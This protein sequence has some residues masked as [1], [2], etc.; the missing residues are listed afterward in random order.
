MAAR[1]VRIVPMSTEY[2]RRVA[3]RSQKRGVK[4]SRSGRLAGVLGELL[5]TAGVLVLLFLGW[6]VWLG[7]LIIGSTQAAQAQ[8]QSK[9]WSKDEP[10]KPAVPAQRAD[11]G[12]PPA[13]AAPDRTTQFAN[14][15][16]PR[17]GAGYTRPVAEGISGDVLRTN[18][19]HYRGTQMPGE[20]GNAA[21]AAHRTG[22]GSP[23]FDIEKLQIGDSIY[24]E[25]EAGWYRYVVRSLEY[26][27]PTGVGVLDP[28]PQVAGVAP[29][30][31][32]LTLTSCNPVFTADERII[33][34]SLYDTWYP[35][36]GGPPAEIAPLVQ[37]A[38]AG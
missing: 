12:P 36:A 6:Q 3:R 25:M 13:Q 26:V 9:A 38:A 10:T 18:V 34:Y 7:N 27:L 31:R 2:G 33:V 1:S 23:F 22:N 35:R 14:M 16:I 17:F 37:A 32:M 19:G 4:Q 20:V 15:I 24:V 30:D 21:F 29:T 11:P 28:V 5:I 8:A